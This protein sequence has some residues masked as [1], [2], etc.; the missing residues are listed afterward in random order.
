MS[1]A[2]TEIFAKTTFEQ[3]SLHPGKSEFNHSYTCSLIDDSFRPCYGVLKNNVSTIEME[4]TFQQW[5][6]GTEE[7][8]RHNLLADYIHNAAITNNILDCISFSTRVNHARKLAT[9]WELEIAHLTDNGDDLSVVDSV[10]QFDAVVVAS[11][12]YHAPN[13]P[14]IA[15]LA[16]WKEAFPNRVSHS[17]R[18]R[19]SRG[20]ENQNVLLIGA[21]VSSID[22]A[23]DL[24]STA[25]SVYQSSRSGLYDLPSHLLP[26]NA[27]RVDG[28]ELFEPLSTTKL[29]DDGAIPGTVILQTGKKLCG[30]HRI[31]ICTGYHVSFPFMREY[32][33]DF[34]RP[35]DASETAIVTDG[36]QTH[37]LHKDIFYIPDPTLAFI[38]V[39]YH[40]A[41]FTLFEFQ[42]M[43]LASIFSGSTKLPCQ[44]DMR[45]EYNERLKRKGAGRSFHSLK[46]E[47]DEIAYV[48]DLVTMVNDRKSS[49][50]VMKGHS[51]KWLQAY[52]M[53]RRRMELLFSTVRDPH[54]DQ[55]ILQTAHGC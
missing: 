51:E 6:D 4:T 8:I 27:A 44:S 7:F 49:G 15:G 55:K 50:I 5:D 11:G 2:M 39:P 9:S 23:K 10:E 32:H 14:V 34:V 3:P 13:I 30:L 31:I 18:Y 21:G 46:H 52:Q 53:R 22:I 43:A 41:T 54:V 42:A 25:A 33:N 26:A 24:G 36:I 16:A 38:G 37:N 47:G 1:T 20:F 28:V 19:S 40:V 29:G 48:N 35:E 45:I 17:K 12:H